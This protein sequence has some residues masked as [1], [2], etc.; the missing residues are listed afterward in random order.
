MPFPPIGTGA[1]GGGFTL[2]PTQNVFTG[3]NRAAAESARDTYFTANPSNL[4]SYNNDTNLNIRLE[5]QESGDSVA[6]YQVRNT[7]GDAWLDNSSAIGVAGPAG[8]DGTD[9]TATVPNLTAGEFVIGGQTAG[10]L[11]PAS[12]RETSDMI[13]FDKSAMLPGGTISLEGFE[14]SNPGGQLLLRDTISD[15]T[16][17][18]A[19]R[20][21]DE[22]NGSGQFNID[23]IQ[24]ATTV[25]FQTRDDET[26]TSS[27]I[28][29]NFTEATTAFILEWQ[30]SAIVTGSGKFY[31][32]IHR[33]TSASDP[34][35][36]RSHTPA[37]VAAEDVFTLDGGNTTHDTRAHPT[38]LVGGQ[39]YYARFIGVGGNFTAGGTTVTQADIDAGGIFTVVGQKVPFYNVVFQPFSQSRIALFDEKE[40]VLGN[41][42]VEGQILSSTT[43]GVRSWIN[44]P[45]GGASL[46]VQDEGTALST[47]ATTLNFVGAGVTATGTG[48]V[49]TITI[50]GGTTPTPTAAV[51]NFSINIPSTVNTGADLNNQRTIQF[52]TANV[53]TIATLRLEVV[54]GNNIDLTV[55]SSD[56][57]HSQSVSLTGIDTSSAGTVTF[58]I[59]GTTTGGDTI[60]SNMVS[61]TIRAVSADE[62][63][64][65]GTRATNDFATVDT[66][67]LT[68]VDVQPPGSEYTISGSWPATQFIGILEP[69][70]RPISSIVETAFNQET[71]SSWTRTASARTINGQTYDLLIQQNNGPS[72][73]FEF[74]VTHA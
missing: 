36:Y 29:V 42:T 73:N 47:A 74:R 34:V 71:L 23:S 5:Y 10:T 46:T 35:W 60:M 28:G 13:E 62:Q 24:P 16:Y 7:A 11:A 22:T 70:D 51:T 49:K 6:L 33:G 61:V 56:G 26:L 18:V 4:A 15:I 2:G 57:A 68:A 50:S 32:V 20:S 3:V 67:S 43:T 69:T 52:T 27:E 17:S 48:A 55:P 19:G 12:V 38:L 65:Y 59:T 45:T 63:A 37:Q 53:A 64:Y 39:Q 40:D 44:V 1:G 14:I 21:F 72:G 54:T 41:P 8:T 25:A 9:G 58:Q 30:S 31:I 66:A